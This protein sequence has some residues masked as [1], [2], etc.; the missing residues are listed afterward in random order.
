M[1]HLSIFIVSLLLC[2]ALPL[3]SQAEDLPELNQEKLQENWLDTFYR[4]LAEGSFALQGNSRVRINET[5]RNA[6][7]G[8]RLQEENYRLLGNVYGIGADEFYGNFTLT[9]SAPKTYLRELHF[10]SIRPAWGEGI[11]FRR[12]NDNK[13]IGALS[14]APHP[15][16]YSP[17]GA[18]LLTGKH[19]FSFFALA[20]LQNRRVS[21][22]EDRI[23]HLYQSRGEKIAS[24]A[25]RIVSG[26]MAY[27]PGILKLGTLFYL[28]SYDRRFTDP[29]YAKHLDAISAFAGLKGETMHIEAEAALLNQNQ[30]LQAEAGLKL[31]E[32]DQRWGF[33]W[34]EGSQMPAYASRPAVLSAKGKG[35]ELNWDLDYRADNATSLGFQQALFCRQHSLENPKWLSRSNFYLRYAPQGAIYLLQFTRFDKEVIAE[36]DSSYQNTRPVHY[37]ALLK[38]QHGISKNLSFNMQ[39]RYQREDK[40]STRNDGVYW[41]NAFLFKPRSFGLEAGLKSWQ[42]RRSLILEDP[43]SEDYAGSAIAT[44]DEFLCFIAPSLSLKSFHLKAELQYSLKNAKTQVLVTAGF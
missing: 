43:D 9:A 15:H 34:R 37:R 27:E 21:L 31:Q 17:L 23:S 36:Q 41:E 3:F 39:F 30:A 8:L 25:E 11:V 20:S 6:L 38:L 40:L 4:Q 1:K 28:Q 29:E 12:S 19:N 7:L 44:G 24:S 2:I 42:S 14:P 18:A 22:S 16:S 26:G 5:G 32:L 10:G 33:S 13:G 35:Y